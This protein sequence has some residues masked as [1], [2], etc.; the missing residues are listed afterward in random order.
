M[1]IIREVCSSGTLPRCV[2]RTDTYASTF[3]HIELLV[4]EA[5][6]DFPSLPSIAIEVVKYGGQRF[7][8]TTGIEFNAPEGG[9]VPDAY[10]PILE[11]EFTL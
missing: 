2:I 1:Q 5:R 8:R 9:S 4:A 7:K 10:S 6:T 11:L 3:E